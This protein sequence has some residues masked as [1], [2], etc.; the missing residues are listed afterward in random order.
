VNQSQKHAT[1]QM[2]QLINASAAMC[3]MLISGCESAFLVQQKLGF[4]VRVQ[5]LVVT[6]AYWL[7]VLWRTLISFV[8]SADSGRFVMH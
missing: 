2:V 6:V 7:L 4:R 3:S 8:V 5:W 1:Q